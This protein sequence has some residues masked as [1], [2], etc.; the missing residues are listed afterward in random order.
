MIFKFLQR[1]ITITAY[2]PDH[3][4][5]SCEEY[6]IVPSSKFVPDWW[7]KTQKSEFNFEKF[8]QK[9]TVKSCVG[10]MG[11]FQNGYIIPMW[12]DLAIQTVENIWRY[13]FADERSEIH[14]H[15]DRQIPGF[16]E[17]YHKMKMVSPWLL[18]SSCDLKYCYVQPFY[19]FT[20]PTPFLTPYGITTSLKKLSSTNIFLFFEKKPLEVIIKAGTPMLQIIPLTERPIIFKREIIPRQDYIK[21]VSVNDKIWFGA[22]ALKTLTKKEKYNG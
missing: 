7:K 13:N 1:P 19:G 14:S 18:K 3:H 17:N 22:T 16:Y 15:G 5:R 9:L 12:S 20:N 2:A 11:T 8:E 6:P 21:L 4:L 10:I